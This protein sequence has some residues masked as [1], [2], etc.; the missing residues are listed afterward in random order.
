MYVGNIFLVEIVY[1]AY[2]LWASL[3]K[4]EQPPSFTDFKYCIDA[5][6]MM[7]FVYL[8]TKRTWVA[9]KP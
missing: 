4:G 3:S 8:A 2:D 7:Q 1:F 5:L 6:F 9:E